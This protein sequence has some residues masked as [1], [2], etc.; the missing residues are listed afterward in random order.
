ML[1][2]KDWSPHVHTVA[3]YEL[4]KGR[5]YHGAFTSFVFVE[6]CRCG[7]WRVM[8]YAS[9]LEAELAHQRGTAGLP[10]TSPLHEPAEVHHAH[11]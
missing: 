2:R 1:L 5:A 10:G 11:A 4:A 7:A 9:P 8:D 3:W 6:L